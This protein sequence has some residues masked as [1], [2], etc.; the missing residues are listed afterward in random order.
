MKTAQPHNYSKNNLNL[1]L[2]D[3]PIPTPKPGQALLRV[4]TAGVNPLDNM[5]TRGEVKLITSYTLPLIAG[6][7]VVGIIESLNGKSND[8]AVGDR[9]FAR[10]PLK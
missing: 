3:A 8:L 1:Q 10:L 2:Q 9:V 7:E 5:I 6:N 4:L